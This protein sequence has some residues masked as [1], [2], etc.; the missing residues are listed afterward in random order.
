MRLALAA[1]AAAIGG[2][3]FWR[4]DQIG[5]GAQRVGNATRQSIH[6]KRSGRKE[7]LTQLGEHVY[8]N[9][10]GDEGVDHD[11]DIARIISELQ[12]IDS[13]REQS[14]EDTTETV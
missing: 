6:D 5:R 10:T 3:V 1:A 8:A 4:R 7:L 2:L 9:S 13:Q 14:S 12:E 11:A